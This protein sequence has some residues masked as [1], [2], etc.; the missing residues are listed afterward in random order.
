M[1]SSKS[2][3]NY[4]F[5]DCHDNM[6]G[7]FNLINSYNISLKFLNVF[8]MWIGC[9]SLKS[10]NPNDKRIILFNIMLSNS[11]TIEDI[12]P[13]FYIMI[14][15]IS[16]INYNYIYISSHLGKLY[17]GLQRCTLFWPS[18]INGNRI[19]FRWLFHVCFSLQNWF[20]CLENI[21]FLT[22]EYL[23]PFRNF[24]NDRKLLL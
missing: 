18:C 8:Y 7:I 6:I 15:R 13:F 1:R 4:N 2:L 23:D 11:S 5:F 3:V 17:L 16:L 22:T 10:L 14:H 20:Y 12:K 21:E 19:F 24:N 9:F